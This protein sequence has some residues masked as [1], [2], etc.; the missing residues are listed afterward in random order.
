MG[1]AVAKLAPSHTQLQLKVTLLDIRPMIWRRLLVPA[2]I[3]LPKLHAVLQIAFGWTN[4]H[5]HAFRCGH[6]S[7]EAY[8]P[9]TWE[10]P[11]DDDERHDE[12]EFRLCDLLHGKGDCLLYEYDFGDSWRHEVCVE[13]V[14][15]IERPARVACVAGARAAP[16]EDCG[17]IPGYQEL[18]EAMRKPRHPERERLLEWLGGPYDPEAFDLEAINAEL[19]RRKF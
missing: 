11:F 5:L 4:S 9:D 3:K 14:L 16:P 17:S 1:K 7:Y 6:Q 10:E 19:R 15:P 8:Y 12:S 2:A 18:V 13:K